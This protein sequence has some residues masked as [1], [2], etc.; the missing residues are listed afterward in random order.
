MQEALDFTHQAQAA[1]EVGDI[2]AAE[3]F[4]SQALEKAPQNSEVRTS[5]SRGWRTWL[6]MHD[7][8]GRSGND[9]AQPFEGVG[10]VMQ[11]RACVLKQP[12]LLA[13]TPLA[14]G[15]HLQAP[16]PT[17]G[18]PVKAMSTSNIRTSLLPHPLPAS[19]AQ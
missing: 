16:Y 4:M 7:R 10:T 15:C 11:P 18:R 2:A 14:C 5:R 6:V 13:C 17:H 3:C 1:L 12:S 19:V 8:Y 9:S